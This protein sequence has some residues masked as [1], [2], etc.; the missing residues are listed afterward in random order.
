MVFTVSAIIH[1][2]AQLVVQYAPLPKG[3]SLTGVQGTIWNGSA[4]NVRWQRQNLG[5]V[6]WQLQASKLFSGKAQAQVR[7]GRG[8]DM[9][10][11]GRGIVGYAMSGP[12][13]EKPDCIVTGRKKVMAYAPRLPV[14]LDLTGQVELSIKKPDLCRTFF[15]QSAEGSVVWNTDKNR[16]AAGRSTNRPGSG[17]LYLCG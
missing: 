13:A 10:F 9:Q 7:F 12:Y 15:C 17:Q 5:Q 14:P 8:S 16:H 4:V 3:L 6:H 2:P 11:S 1:L